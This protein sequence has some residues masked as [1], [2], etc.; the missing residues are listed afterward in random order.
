MV[1]FFTDM[2][3][4]FLG[5]E[6]RGELKNFFQNYQAFVGKAKIILFQV[7]SEFMKCGLEI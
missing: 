2:D 3:K 1:M 6:M 4:Q 5:I 7:G